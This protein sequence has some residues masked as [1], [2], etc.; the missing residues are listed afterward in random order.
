MQ[1][2]H[3]G[4]LNQIEFDQHTWKINACFKALIQFEIRYVNLSLPYI[5]MGI[6]SV[7]L[8]FVFYFLICGHLTVL[9]KISTDEMENPAQTLL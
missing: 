7:L 4:F 2:Q 1:I 5:A 6:P 3:L 9:A 8:F